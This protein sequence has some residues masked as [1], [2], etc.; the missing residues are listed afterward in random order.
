MFLPATEVDI[1]E[2]GYLN[3]RQEPEVF[4]ADGPTSEQMFVADEMRYKI[5]HEYAGTPVDCVGGYKGSVT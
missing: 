5:R 4:V 2:M 3:G 1:I